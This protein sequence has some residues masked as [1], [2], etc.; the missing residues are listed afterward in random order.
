M[1]MPD[2]PA[3]VTVAWLPMATELL[4][5]ALAE[6]PAATAELPLAVAPVPPSTCAWACLTP[7][8]ASRS[9]AATTTV[10]EPARLPR[11]GASSETATHAPS[12]AFQIV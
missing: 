11:P 12:D 2:V 10:D 7:P 4:P 9:T 6:L 8:S 3:D 5:L 1:A